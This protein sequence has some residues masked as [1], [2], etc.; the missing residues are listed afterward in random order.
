MSLYTNH[1]SMCGRVRLLMA[2]LSTL[3]C[4]ALAT[5]PSATAEDYTLVRDSVVIYHYPES[6]NVYYDI[7]VRTNRAL[8]RQDSGSVLAG[9]KINGYG[10]DLQFDRDQDSTGGFAEGASR[11]APYCYAQ[12]TLNVITAPTGELA[13][14]R[15]GQEVQ[16]EVYI[17]GEPEPLTATV[18]MRRGGSEAVF[19]RARR[20]L[21]CERTPEDLM[22]ERLTVDEGVER[23]EVNRRP[24]ESRVGLL[25][26][27]Q[28]FKV[29]RL[30]PSGKYAHGFAYGNLNKHGWVLTSGLV[31]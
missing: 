18:E 16:V 15:A 29:R 13:R 30:S 28:T 8:P 1:S 26:P 11:A 19:E 14:P 24:N 25:R 7:I 9:A 20:D 4:V 17:A 2:V 22:G 23:L 21:G 10:P 27:P 12:T 3:V 31:H 5:S 6:G